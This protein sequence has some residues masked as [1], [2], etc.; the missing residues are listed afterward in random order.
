MAELATE[1]PDCESK[2]I[3]QRTEAEGHRKWLEILPVPLRPLRR[4]PQ[5]RQTQSQH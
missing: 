1:C 3:L 4:N 2:G 5:N